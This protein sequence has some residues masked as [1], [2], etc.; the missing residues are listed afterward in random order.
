[1][2]NMRRKPKI[3]GNVSVDLIGSRMRVMDFANAASVGLAGTVVDE[4]RNMITLKE[5]DKERRL[6]KSQHTFQITT[7][8]GKMT[9]KGTDLIGRPEERLKKWLKQNKRPRTS[10]LR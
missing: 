6:I 8:K 1:M 9:I 2:V 4:T 3:D 10:V 5:G 7:E